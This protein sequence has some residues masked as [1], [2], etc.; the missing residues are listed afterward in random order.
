M[1]RTSSWAAE[2]VVLLLA[3]AAVALVGPWIAPYAPSQQFTDF[4]HAP[5][6][7]PRM[8]GSDGRLRAPFVYPLRLEDRLERRFVEDRSRPM[9][10]R[11]FAHGSLVSVEPSRAPWFPL[12]T[13]ALG[14]DVLSRLLVGA[15]LSLGVA[16]ASAA[17]AL[18]LGA[19]AGSLAGL[20]GHHVDE[21]VMRVADFVIALPAIYVVLALRAA[22]PLV[23]SPASVFWTMVGVFALV[24]WPVAARG[25]RVIVARERTREYAEAARAVGAGRTRLLL[26]HLLPAT[27]G[28]LLVQATLLLPAFVLAEATL[29]FIG[30]GFGEPVPSWGVMLQE[31][32]RGPI[33][34]DAPWLIAPAAAIVVVMLGVN[35][36]AADRSSVQLHHDHSS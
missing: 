4:V 29:S 23:L 28:F 25:V 9:P 34:A 31:A 14:R 5:P 35:L 8:V 3:L 15:R 30:L 18:L 13:D 21:V 33:L 32:G 16:F 10:L 7:R 11:F 26:H 22:L 2:G 12:G 36:V 24:G 19:L 20:V 27:R 17:G 1:R 6:M